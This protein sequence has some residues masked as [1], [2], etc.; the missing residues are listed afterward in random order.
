MKRLTRE[1]LT[2]N[3][4]FRGLLAWVSFSLVAPMAYAMMEDEELVVL[5]VERIRRTRHDKTN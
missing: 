1:F 5:N 3:R 2:S 4:R